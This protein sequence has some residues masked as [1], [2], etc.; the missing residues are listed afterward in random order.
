MGVVNKLDPQ[1]ANQCRKY[2]MDTTPQMPSG[3]SDGALVVFCGPHMPLSSGCITLDTLQAIKRHK[4]RVVYITCD[5]LLQFD[6]RVKRYG[7]F[8]EGW[9]EDALT[10]DKD[11]R[12]I[13]HGG[14]DHHFKT[15]AQADKM[16]ILPGWENYIEVPLNMCG[17]P[18]DHEKYTINT[19]PGLDLLYCGAFRKNRTD[20][21]QKYFCQP[22]A[23]QWTLSTTQEKKFRNM[24]GFQARTIGPVKGRIWDMINKSCVQL[25]AGDKCDSSCIS[26][27]LP[28]RYWE[29]V[30]AK[31]PVVFDAE[32]SS[33]DMEPNVNSSCELADHISSLRKRPK[34]RARLVERQSEQIVGFNPFEMWRIDEWFGY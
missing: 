19:E 23:K 33:W 14:F 8:L 10:K 28:T 3:A 21:F 15:K 12:Y 25:V 29:A 27:P 11:Y 6:G 1:T 32:Y 20:F 30:A 34:K 2:G 4:G 13:L 22:Q 17:I 7:K 9:D 31:S 26:T 18:P 16:K 24:P 5:Y